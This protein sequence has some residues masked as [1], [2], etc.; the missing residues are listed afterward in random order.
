[1]S[2][3]LSK[4]LREKYNVRSL[5]LRRG[6]EVEIKIGHF[7]GREGKITRVYRKEFK[8]YVERVQRDKINGQSVDVPIHPSN[9][10][11][12]SLHLDL[13]RKN[14]LERKAKARKAT[15]AA[16]AAM[17]VDQA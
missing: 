17:D 11:I 16:A 9:V 8:I 4:E 10:V 12:K 13:D 15:A 3:P 1:M 14:L 6:D 7:K 2:A 5:P